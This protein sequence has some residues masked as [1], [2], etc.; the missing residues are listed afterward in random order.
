MFT[1][2][3]LAASAT[4]SAAVRYDQVLAGS[5]WGLGRPGLGVVA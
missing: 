3:G 4:I 2:C 5:I 1:P